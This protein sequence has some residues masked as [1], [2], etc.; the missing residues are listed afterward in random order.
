MSEITDKIVRIMKKFTYIIYLFIFIW[1]NQNE[2]FC[3]DS[4]S[5]LSKREMEYVAYKTITAQRFYDEYRDKI[6]ITTD[7]EFP[8]EDK[9]EFLLDSN[10][11]NIYIMSYQTFCEYPVKYFVKEYQT[12]F[13]KYGIYI[14]GNYVQTLRDSTYILAI[15]R[16]GD[17]FY[18]NKSLNNDYKKL[19]KYI[20]RKIDTPK[21]AL[22]IAYSYILT[23]YYDPWD[24]I[25]I[26]DSTNIKEKYLKQ[27]LFIENDSTNIIDFHKYNVAI[28]MVKEEDNSYI[29]NLF[30]FQEHTNAID[31]IKI[32]ISEDGGVSSE[33][34]NIRK[35]DY[36]RDIY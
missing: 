20:Y 18:L 2:V 9:K 23:K 12:E 8:R 15:N 7:N 3:Q 14:F 33:N 17:M 32:Y 24:E 35:P 5:V 10:I 19:F 30:V 13:N 21:K 6:L 29:V 1:I 31:Y 25:L 22:E 34:K 4:S 11:T 26:I 16:F 28:P 36:I 27:T